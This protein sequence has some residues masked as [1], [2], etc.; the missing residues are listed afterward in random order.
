MADR[1]IGGGGSAVI[2]Q[3]D[4]GRVEVLRS[5]GGSGVRDTATIDV[6]TF[7]ASWQDEALMDHPRARHN[8]VLLPD[9]TI[10]AHRRPE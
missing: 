8:L 7:P 5:G 1:P 4:L 2:Y 9:R 3:T 10:L 6:T